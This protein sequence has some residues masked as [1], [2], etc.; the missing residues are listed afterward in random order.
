ME[1]DYTELFSEAVYE[2]ERTVRTHSISILNEVLADSIFFALMAI[3]GSVT[4]IG[5]AKV[6]GTAIK[7]KHFEND[8]LKK[9]L[10]LSR[11]DLDKMQDATLATIMNDIQR[12]AP[13]SEYQRAMV[14]YKK[15]V[16]CF[17]LKKEYEGRNVNTGKTTTSFNKN[18]IEKLGRVSYKNIQLKDDKEI[19]AATNLKVILSID[20]EYCHSL[21]EMD[22]TK[23]LRRHFG[24]IEKGMTKFEV[25]EILGSPIRIDYLK[26][27]QEKYEWSFNTAGYSVGYSYKGISTRTYMS[28][29]VYKLTVYFRNDEVEE[30]RTLNL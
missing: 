28:G 17:T 18:E 30:T 21:S 1:N 29:R 6:I 12:F 11:H 13:E 7:D 14:A 25:L 24:D 27:G 8:L 23:R 20:D 3:V 26:N 5:V 10:L 22:F 15:L 9:R 4:A 2:N 16:K 19:E